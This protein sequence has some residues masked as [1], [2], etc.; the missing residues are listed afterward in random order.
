MGTTITADASNSN[1]DALLSVTSSPTVVGISTSDI[2][3]STD[4]TGTPTDDNNALTSDISTSITYDESNPTCRTQNAE[5]DV[6][7]WHQ[8]SELDSKDWPG[9]CKTQNAVFDMCNSIYKTRTAE[10][11]RWDS[12]LAYTWDAEPHMLNPTCRTRKAGVYM[13]DWTCRTWNARLDEWNPTCNARNEIINVRNS[14][15]SDNNVSKDKTVPTN[16]DA[17][18]ELGVSL[19][20]LFALMVHFFREPTH[21]PRNKFADCWDLFFYCSS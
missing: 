7:D 15:S 19:F 11:N 2:G 5:L 1:I 9:K 16:G 20:A 6:T 12:T 18:S 17:I 10:L 3:S 21:G 8:K 14:A 4:G 13:R